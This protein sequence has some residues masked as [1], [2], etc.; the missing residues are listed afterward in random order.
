MGSEMLARGLCSQERLYNEDTD[1][2]LTENAAVLQ[3][4]WSAFR[5]RP[6][7]GGLRTKGL[8]MK[9]F[10]EFMDKAHL[11]DEMF[12]YQVRDA[13]WVMMPKAQRA[14]GWPC[15]LGAHSM[16]KR[17]RRRRAWRSF[18]AACT[19]RTRW[20]TGLNTPA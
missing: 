7:G 17:V 14:S 15:V 12:G 20:A 18:G 5:C 19:G 1:L 16:A 9:G 6:D 3:A 8:S 4:V 10:L 11:Y 2:V 13:V